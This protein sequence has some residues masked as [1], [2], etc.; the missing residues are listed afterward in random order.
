MYSFQS[1]CLFRCHIKLPQ[2][3]GKLHTEVCAHK[4]EFGNGGRI[5][6]CD[7]RVLATGHLTNT[8]F[9]S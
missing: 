1:Q 4:L 6:A 5:A 2:F 7:K 9:H 3:F 8:R